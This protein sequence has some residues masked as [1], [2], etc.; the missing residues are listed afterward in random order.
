MWKDMFEDNRMDCN[1]CRHL[2]ITEKQQKELK[3]GGFGFAPHICMKYDKRVFHRTQSRFHSGYLYP[4]EEC[5]KEN[6]Y[7]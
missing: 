6:G 7:E 3:I 1:D 2:M 5:E 4:C